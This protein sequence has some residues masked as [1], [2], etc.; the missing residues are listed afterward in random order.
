MIFPTRL[1]FI[2]LK[3]Y[4]LCQISLL[5]SF[6]SVTTNAESTFN[7]KTVSL[8]ETFTGRI[9]SALI[10]THSDWPLARAGTETSNVLPT[11]VPLILRTVRRNVFAAAPA[12]PLLTTFTRRALSL[13]GAKRNC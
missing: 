6:D 9:E 11:G 8:S 10:N 2:E 13:V 4:K 3:T 7:L 1:N 5:F 12:L